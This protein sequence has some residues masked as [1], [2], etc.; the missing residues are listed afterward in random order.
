[1]EET[2]A[3]SGECWLAAL[4][5]PTWRNCP[6]NEFTTCQGMTSD[7]WALKLIRNS[8]FLELRVIPYADKTKKILKQKHRML[9]YQILKGNVTIKETSHSSQCDQHKIHEEIYFGE[10]KTEQG[11]L[12]V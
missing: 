5:R 11:E 8:E 4:T 7:L 9:I 3:L 12:V 1:M 10:N 6:G 2:V